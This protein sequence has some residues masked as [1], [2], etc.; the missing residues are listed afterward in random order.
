MLVPQGMAYAV[1]AGLPP[2]YG[3][4]AGLVPLLIYPLLATS[5]HM[6]VGPIAI[7]MLIVAA[8]VGM[9]AQADTDR[10]LALIILLTAMVGAL[11]ILMGVARLGFLVSFLARPVIAGFA[12]AAAIIIAFSQLGNLIGVEL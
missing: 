4:Y 8:G 3:L 2:I 11:Q 5:R 12:A 7:D 10:Y 1:I 6:A 9:L